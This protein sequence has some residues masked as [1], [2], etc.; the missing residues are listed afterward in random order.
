M[1]MNGLNM[2]GVGPPLAGLASLGLAPA[3]QKD[4][5]QLSMYSQKTERS[6]RASG[7]PFPPDIRQGKISVQLLPEAFHF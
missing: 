6:M 3:G 7:R 4:W 1:S 5:D 2:A